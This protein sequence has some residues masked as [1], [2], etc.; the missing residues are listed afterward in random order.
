MR[1]LDSSERYEKTE[2]LNAIFERRLLKMQAEDEK[3]IGI[4]SL[5]SI[6]L[7][8]EVITV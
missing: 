7:K 1:K 3:K 4:E 2:T 8:Y 5:I 6:L